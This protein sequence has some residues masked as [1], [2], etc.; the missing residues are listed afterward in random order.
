MDKW[1]KMVPVIILLYAKIYKQ[2]KKIN[3][4]IRLLTW[5]INI[6]VLVLDELKVINIEISGGFSL[7]KCLNGNTKGFHFRA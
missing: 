1:R 7:F 2:G 6:A 5:L 4:L 3:R